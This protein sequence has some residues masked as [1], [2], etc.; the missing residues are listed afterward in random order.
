M[1]SFA[2]LA[3]R[4]HTRSSRTRPASDLRRQPR[5]QRGQDEAQH[6]PRGRQRHVSHTV[7]IDRF[8]PHAL[9]GCRGSVVVAAGSGK[10]GNDS[11]DKKMNKDIL[12]VD[13]FTTV[14]FAPKDVH[15]NDCC[16]RRLDHSGERSVH[17]A[18]HP[19]RPDDSD[20]D[21]H[22]WIE[23]NGEGAI[24]R[25]LCAVGSQEPELPDLESRE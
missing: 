17:P 1:K 16:F 6:D 12:K 4:A 11:R 2:V 25:S 10:T 8:R 7:R 24:R 18:R 5:C 22:R 15:R 23:G 9:P 14:S 20:A 3:L 21:S 19:S 13:Q